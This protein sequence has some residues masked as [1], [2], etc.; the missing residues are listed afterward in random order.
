[1]IPEYCKCVFVFNGET[2][3]LTEDYWNKI[4][5]IKLDNDIKIT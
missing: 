3:E 1:M 5:E 2:F 4:N